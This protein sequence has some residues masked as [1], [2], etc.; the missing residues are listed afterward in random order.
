MQCRV[1]DQTRR[2]STQSVNLG[3][4]PACGSHGQNRHGCLGQERARLRF[5]NS[6]ARL[7]LKTA[8]VTRFTNPYGHIL[9]PCGVFLNR[10][11]VI[12]A[13]ASRETLA[14]FIAE[15]P[16]LKS[17]T[18]RTQR[19]PDLPAETQSTTQG[20]RRAWRIHPVACIKPVEVVQRALLP[21]RRA[22][23]QGLPCFELDGV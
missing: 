3:P 8:V 9:I 2:H 12:L 10:T 17:Q 1:T 16:Q 14:Q 21:L 13:A 23:R 4:L 6:K 20:P 22:G 7:H 19:S 18:P 15:L 5:E 11:A